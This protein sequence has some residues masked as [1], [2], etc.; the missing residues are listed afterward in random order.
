MRCADD[1]AAGHVERPQRAGAD[2]AAQR[3]TDRR[4]G[5]LTGEDESPDAEQR[6]QG[7]GRLLDLRQWL[8]KKA[9]R[10]QGEREPD[11][12]P[13]EADDGTQEAGPRAGEGGE[14]EQDEH[15]EVEGVHRGRQPSAAMAMALGG[16]SAPV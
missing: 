16:S 15:E 2:P 7:S 6:D 13:A 3:R 11:D 5:G 9:C 8:V 14:C 4:T 12:R 1:G 10:D